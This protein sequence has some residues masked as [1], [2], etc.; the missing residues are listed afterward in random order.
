MIVYNFKLCEGSFEALLPYLGSLASSI[1]S[2]RLVDGWVLGCVMGAMCYEMCACNWVARAGET[3][4]SGAGVRT[5]SAH[6]GRDSRDR[7]VTCHE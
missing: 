7:A 4:E 6:Y 1:R 3:R 2:R 5:I